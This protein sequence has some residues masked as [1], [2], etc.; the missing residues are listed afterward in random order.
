MNE[1]GWDS[2]KSMLLA[3]TSLDN[4]IGNLPNSLV[5]VEISTDLL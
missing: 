3:L 2:D 4:R 1:C 5:A